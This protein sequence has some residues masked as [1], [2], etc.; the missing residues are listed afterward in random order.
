MDI[1]DYDLFVDL[2][3][4][5]K[6]HKLTDMA[7]AAIIKVNIL[8]ELGRI[9][10]WYFRNV[11][12][13]GIYSDIVCTILIYR[14][15]GYMQKK[16]QIRCPHPLKALLHQGRKKIQKL[17]P[18]HQ[19]FLKMRRRLLSRIRAEVMILETQTKVLSDL[20]S[21]QR[22]DISFVYVTNNNAS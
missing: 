12:F 16:Y 11:C 7:D 3:H 13:I 21:I 8:H 5:A 9:N 22:I 14:H 18:M 17:L 2:H 1:N 15:S 19:T 10:Q 20:K 6:R 4:A